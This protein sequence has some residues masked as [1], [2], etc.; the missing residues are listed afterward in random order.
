MGR[1]Q[2]KSSSGGYGGCLK[3]KVDLD[4]SSLILPDPISC[5]V[6]PG[7]RTYPSEGGYINLR[8]YPLGGGGSRAREASK[9]Y[10]GDDGEEEGGEGEKRKKKTK[11]NHSKNKN[12]NKNKSTRKNNNM[13]RSIRIGDSILHDE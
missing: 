4:S 1:S 5:P 6:K 3:F 7:K 2:R 11:E 12:N 9:A 8:L 13:S 10:D